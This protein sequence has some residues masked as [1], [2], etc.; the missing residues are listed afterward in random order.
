[1]TD[2]HTTAPQMTAAYGWR[3]REVIDRDGE[4]IG[5]LEEIYLDYETDTPEWALVNTGLLGTKSNFVPLAG[6]A[7]AREDVQVQFTKQQVTEAPGIA[8]EGELSQ[9]QEATLYRHYG[10]EYAKSRSQSGLPA[11]P[12]GAGAQV[13]V[14]PGDDAMTRSEEELHIGKAQRVRGRARL[15]KYVVT[16]EVQQTIPVKREKA[17]LEY[18]PVTEENAGEPTATPDLSEDEHEIVLSEEEVII[19]KRTVPKE[20]VRIA[21]DVETDEHVVSEEV[22][23]ERIQAEG[24]VDR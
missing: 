23:K 10:L 17:R 4:K 24:D 14:S 11:G 6:A 1:M 16:E 19:E 5:K 2:A 7:P 12:A 22:R 20:R 15:R 13:G 21:K 9:E 8:D 3:G 18:E